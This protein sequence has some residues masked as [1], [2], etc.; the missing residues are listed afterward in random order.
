MEAILITKIQEKRSA[1]HS[2]YISA[3]VAGII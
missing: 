2:V 1:P 3:A